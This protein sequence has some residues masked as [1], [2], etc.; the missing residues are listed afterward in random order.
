[1]LTPGGF[2]S[3]S[4]VR[5]APLYPPGKFYKYTFPPIRSSCLR[6]PRTLHPSLRAPAPSLASPY[7]SPVITHHIIFCSATPMTSHDP[8]R[9]CAHPSLLLHGYIMYMLNELLA[10]YPR[11]GITGP[12]HS[13]KT[14]LS[15]LVTDRPVIHCDNLIDGLRWDDIPSAIIQACYA[16]PLL[17]EGCQVPRAV[18]AGLKLDAIL[19][20]TEPFTEL[21]PKQRAFAK[22]IMTILHQVER[23]RLVREIV[24]Y[25]NIT[26]HEL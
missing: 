11:L 16:S 25:N 9:L 18:R 8:P 23:I 7:P 4:G 20:L 1:M 22:G 12:P 17:V 3:G 15:A 21:T 14:S 13:G 6:A 19:C 10:K 2:L 5:G 26:G 24:W